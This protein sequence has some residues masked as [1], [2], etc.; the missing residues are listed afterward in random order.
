[1]LIPLRTF[2][3]A[4]CKDNIDIFLNVVIVELIFGDD[5]DL[6]RLLATLQYFYNPDHF[7]FRKHLFKIVS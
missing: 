5:L 4:L 6:V 2:I 7:V 3:Q 1:M